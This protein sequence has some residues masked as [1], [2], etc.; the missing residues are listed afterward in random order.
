MKA[1]IVDN[2]L[3]RAEMRRVLDGHADF[4]DGKLSRSEWA[5]EGRFPRWR[6][7][8]CEETELGFRFIVVDNSDGECFVESF[9]TLDGAIL[10]L[11]DCKLTPEKQ[12][13]WDYAGAIRDRG[14][15]DEKRDGLHYAV[16]AP[17]GVRDG[18]FVFGYA[19]K[20]ETHGRTDDLFSEDI[21]RAVVF[22]TRFEAE[23][24]AKRLL[25]GTACVKNVVCVEDEAGEAD[26][27]SE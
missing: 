14:G 5:D 15:I 2:A 19:V 25:P 20:I 7:L 1:V 3:E 9:E 23:K 26:R 4:T 27:V 13:E 10:Y 12:H 21:S 11:T 22:G 18:E 8:D 6:W 17:I 24:A 16:K